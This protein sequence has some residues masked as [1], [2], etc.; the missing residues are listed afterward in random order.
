MWDAAT[1]KQLRVLSFSN[2]QGTMATSATGGLL[3]IG[4]NAVIPGV[5]DVVRVFDTCPAC[6]NAKALLRLAAP[7]VA[8]AGRLTTLERTVVNGA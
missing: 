3:A 8:P 2:F 7:H 5:D 6:E 4:E 1:G